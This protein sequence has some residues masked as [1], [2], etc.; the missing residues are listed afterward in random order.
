MRPFTHIPPAIAK[1]CP[2]I[3]K[4]VLSHTQKIRTADFVEKT[5]LIRCC[6]L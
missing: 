6:G 1:N 2:A 4:K 5:L 3:F